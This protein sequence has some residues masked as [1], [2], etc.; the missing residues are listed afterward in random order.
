[1]PIAVHY[2]EWPSNY[3]SGVPM[4]EMKVFRE[5]TK[6]WADPYIKNGTYILSPNKEWLYGYI[7][8][9][10]RASE[11]KMLKNRIR[12]D[13]RYRTFVEVKSRK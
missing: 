11:V 8:A 12:F 2:A 6:D 5:T 4:S 10:A 9:G 7:P 1:L 13:K 3:L